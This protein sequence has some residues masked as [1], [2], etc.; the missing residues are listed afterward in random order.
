VRGGGGG[1]GVLVA[2]LA[3]AGRCFSSSARMSS[4]AVA[5]LS[6]VPGL[7]MLL[8]ELSFSCTRYFRIS[9]SGSSRFV[10]CSSLAG[11]LS[12]KRTGRRAI[13]FLMAVSISF[14]QGL[15]WNNPAVR[16]M[17]STLGFSRFPFSPVRRSIKV[18]Q[19]TPGG[20][21]SPEKHCRP[22][23]WKNSHSP[24]AYITPGPEPSQS[25]AT[26]L[27]LIRRPDAY[28]TTMEG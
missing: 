11:K 18:S 13:L 14:R 25:S 27:R 15:E 10:H 24:M 5:L 6:T 7:G 20:T 22:R 4:R 16:M 8:S 9:Q 23:S 26:P 1:V 28:V 19:S 2:G 3:G 21:C 17:I 12:S